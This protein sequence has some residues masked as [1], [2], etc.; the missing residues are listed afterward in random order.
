MRPEI[1]LPAYCAFKD[2]RLLFPLGYT[3]AEFAQ[4]ARAFD[5]G[6][7]STGIDGQ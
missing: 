5:A 1:I 2:M 6:H 3:V 7:V 4:T